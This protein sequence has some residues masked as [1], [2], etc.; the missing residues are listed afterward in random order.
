MGA[1]ANAAALMRNEDWR[2]Y[3]TAAVVYQAVQV[4][5]EL[6]SVSDHAVRLRL[7]LDVIAVPDLITTR[8]VSIVSTDPSIASL[9][10]T[11]TDNHETALLT[12]VAQVWTDFAK[13][14]YPT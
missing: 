13:T 6:V 2:H 12:K 8:M 1:V 7:A 14:T 11:L 9:G 10:S 4:Y 3:V 5:T